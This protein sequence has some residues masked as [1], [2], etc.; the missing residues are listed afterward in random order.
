MAKCCSRKALF[1]STVLVTSRIVERIKPRAK[2]NIVRVL[3]QDGEI[4]F[5]LRE[6]IAD[7]DPKECIYLKDAEVVNVLKKEASKPLLLMR[8]E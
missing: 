2:N 6:P 7:E 8:T 3:A 1:L 4:H 5:I